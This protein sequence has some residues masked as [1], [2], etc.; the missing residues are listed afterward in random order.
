MISDKPLMFLNEHGVPTCLS[1]FNHRALVQDFKDSRI[2]TTY[3]QT[4][5]STLGAL[6]ICV[7]I[8]TAQRD[9]II[10]VFC[11]SSVPYI[12][13]ILLNNSSG[14]FSVSRNTISKQNMVVENSQGF[15]TKIYFHRSSKL[16][17]IRGVCFDV[18]VVDSYR[19]KNNTLNVFNKCNAKLSLCTG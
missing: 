1:E 14:I 4:G 3:R 18:L 15:L 17:D 11:D 8:K 19:H 16:K 5:I 10:D 6:N 2:H 12:Q 9:Q 13:N 7:K